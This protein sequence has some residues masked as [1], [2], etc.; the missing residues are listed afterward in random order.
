[1]STKAPY[2]AIDSPNSRILRG[3]GETSQGTLW[4]WEQ[5]GRP[6]SINV[7]IDYYTVQKFLHWERELKKMDYRHFNQDKFY[8]RQLSCIEKGHLE[9]SA[10]FL[11]FSSRV[12]RCWGLTMPSLF[13]AMCSCTWKPHPTGHSAWDSQQGTPGDCLEGTSLV[14][15]WW[16]FVSF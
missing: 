5:E 11:N 12:L 6:F 4:S 14:N 16:L 15:I 13:I 7:T 9:M 1:M 8:H 3:K 2:L 10:D